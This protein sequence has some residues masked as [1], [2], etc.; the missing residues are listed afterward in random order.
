MLGLLALAGL[1]FGVV[2]RLLARRLVRS[3]DSLEQ[4]VM[5]LKAIGE[6]ARTLSISP[7]LEEL[8]RQML[9]S[10][11][12][13]TGCYNVNLF[14]MRGNEIEF[15]AGEGGYVSEMPAPGYRIARS[16]GIIGRV[17]ASGKYLMVDD[18]SRSPYYQYWSGLPNTRSELALPIQLA[19]QVLGVLDLQSDQLH[20]FDAAD[21]EALQVLASQLAVALDNSR[22]YQ[23]ARSRAAEMEQL[24]NISTRRLQ[25]MEALRTVDMAITASLD[26]DTILQV[27]LEQASALLQVDA[28]SVLLYHPQTQS[29]EY[30]A[31][32]GFITDALEHTHLRLGE[33]FAGRAALEQRVVQIADLRW[34]G[35][36][37]VR[38]PLLGQEGFVTY[39]GVPML[40]KGQLKGVLEIFQREA[41]EADVEWLNFLESLAR[42]TAI[43]I[44]NAS[45]MDG[46]EQ[47][48]QELTAA[49]DATIEG[50]AQ[51]LELRDLETAGHSRRVTDLT[52]ALGQAMGLAPAELVQLRRGAL[53]HDIG[54]IGV[55]D[56]ILKKAGGL[57]DEE[58]KEMRNHP[59]YA[60]QILSSIP[61]LR[62]ALDIPYS[63][64]ERWDGGGYPRGLREE[65][66]PLAARIF[67]VVDVWD[68]VT[69]KRCYQDAWPRERAEALIR[70]GAGRHFDAD[71]VQVFL[72]QFAGQN[73]Y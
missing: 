30:A 21:L 34:Q 58:M 46:L 70:E 42:Q 49:Y 25:Q 63:H 3:R 26:L 10:L 37:L 59:Q 51:A 69:H 61:F 39:I 2:A 73:L 71:V 35:D 5:R 31:K 41:F 23:E 38:S 16:S 65:Q 53:L 72:E 4:V 32:R 48:N 68:A 7:G 24:L 22:L 64:H 55:P 20:G 13:I 12:A 62:P 17:A 43:A 9:I 40:V 45:L 36:E 29:L 57:T 18:V 67:A 19:G 52:L 28:A 60:F 11:R 8:T 56:A 44:E 47:A 6:L 66:I 27:M 33:G 15:L 1:V 50:W 14:L 54:K